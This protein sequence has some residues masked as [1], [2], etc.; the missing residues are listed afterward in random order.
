MKWLNSGFG[1]EEMKPGFTQSVSYSRLQLWQHF[2]ISMASLDA[3]KAG[4]YLGYDPCPVTDDA[5]FCLCGVFSYCCLL[6]A[7]F[8]AWHL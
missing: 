4:L 6:F 5:V 8:P 2:I 3:R 1:G 7:G